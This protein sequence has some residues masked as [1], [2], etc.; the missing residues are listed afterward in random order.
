MRILLFFLLV[1]S[2]AFSQVNQT[3]AKGKKQGPWVKTFPNSKVVQYKGQFKD[4]VP[5][6][7]FVHYYPTGEIRMVVDHVPNSPRSYVTFYF[8]N[9]EVMT[10]GQYWNQ[11]RDSIWANF[12]PGGY[13]LN[14]ETYKNDVLNGKRTTFFVQTQ[15]AEGKLAVMSEVEYKN[16]VQDGPYKEFF[17]NGKVK[18][19]G[20]YVAGKEIGEWKE[21]NMEGALIG[22]MRYK[23]GLLHGWAYAYDKKGTEINKLFFHNGIELKGQELD[24]F[25]ETCRKN[26]VDPNQ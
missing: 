4:D 21:Y 12:D 3:D 22:K 26:K 14:V 1:A 20:Q 2:T 11:Q 19:T 10:E 24:I 13:V 5:V 17:S 23:N 8:K 25:L 9:Q 15:E 6:G 7:Q 16:G 18:K